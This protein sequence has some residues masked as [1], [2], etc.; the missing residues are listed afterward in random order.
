M[1]VKSD[2]SKDDNIPDFSEKKT[3]I[4]R[5]LLSLHYNIVL[6]YLSTK[7][8]VIEFNEIKQ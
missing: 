5:Y 6:A 4:K 8:L 7:M 3:S 2:R 1:S